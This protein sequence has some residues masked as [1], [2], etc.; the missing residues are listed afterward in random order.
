MLI[1]AE[2]IHA[3]RLRRVLLT[4]G[5]ASGALCIADPAMAA[6]VIAPG[7]TGTVANP[8]PN[9]T[10][11]CTGTTTG[12]N[13]AST[14]TGSGV[15]IEGGAEVNGVAGSEIRID[16]N[17]GHVIVGGGAT[18]GPAIL[19]D[20]SV[21]VIGD[22][23][24]VDIIDGSVVDQSGN[25]AA[26]IF[27]QG[28]NA[29]IGIGA[30]SQVTV[31]RAVQVHGGG[32]GFL[33]ASL[34]LEAG[35]TLS[36]SSGFVASAMIFGGTDVQNFSI[37]GRIEANDI[38]PVVTLI[39]AGDGNDTILLTATTRFGATATSSTV[40]SFVL[41]GGLGFDRMFFD[42]IDQSLVFDTIGIEQLTVDPG[43]G[44]G[45]S[46][47]RGTHE[48]QE[49][50]VRNGQLD[51]FGQAA[52]GASS[53][54]VDIQ[55]NNLVRFFD[56]GSGVLT[57]RLSGS[58]VF[59]YHGGTH[60][61]AS[62]NFLTGQFLVVDGT[63]VISHS[64][65][66]GD[67]T[68]TNYADVI[69]RDVFIDNTLS[70]NG[71]YIIDGVSTTLTGTNSMN[72][73]ITIRNGDLVIPDVAA[74]GNGQATTP[75]TII[76]EPAGRLTLDISTVQ[77]LDNILVGSGTLQKFLAGDLIINR[78]NSG[79]N[80]Q[81]NLLGG[82]TFVNATDA[83]GTGVIFLNA[84][85]LVTGTAFV[86]NT[87]TGTGEIIRNNSGVTQLLANNSQF[88]GQII[89]N[90]GS[91]LVTN[92]NGLGSATVNLANNTSL[93]VAIASGSTTVNNAISG[94]GGFIKTGLGLVNLTGPNTYSGG[95]DISAGTLRVTGS[96]PLGSGGVSVTT[97][98]TL[99]F[100]NATNATFA[101]AMVGGGTFR[102]LG[103][104]QLT[105]T[106]PFSVGALAID[107]GRVRINGNAT[108]HATVAS[109]AT[110]DGTGRIIGNVI[111]NGTVAPGNSIGTLNVQGNYV[112]GAN[113][114]LDIEFDGSGAIDLLNVTGT[115]TLNGG[116]LRFISLGNAEGSGGTFLTAAGGVTGTFANVQ[117]VGAQLP[118]AVIYQ[119]NSAIMAPSVLTARPSTFN[120]QF[121]AAA[122][123]GF[124][125]MDSVASAANLPIEGKNLW[126]QG[127]GATGKRSASGTTLGYDH[128]SYGMSGGVTV[129]VAENVVIGAAVGWA[130]G[131]IDLGSNGGG[132]DQSSV[133]AGLY[134]RYNADGFRLSA[135][136]VY[137]K[138]DQSTLRNVSFN[139]FSASVDGETKSDLYGGY[140]GLAVP[141]GSTGGWQ[142]DGNVRGGFIHQSQDAYVESGASPLRLA[143][144]KQSVDTVEGQ[145]GLSARKTSG[146][147]DLRLGLG[148]RYVSAQ[149]DRTIPVTFAA[150]NAIISLQGDERDNLHSYV[151]LG[152]GYSVSEN[153]KLNLG[154]AGQV[155]TTD[156]HEARVGLTIGF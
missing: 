118:L 33:G 4:I 24:R 156:R 2:T 72:G 19:R 13:V 18:P 94:G 87:L 140:L 120:A 42:N 57:Q 137:G 83:L 138:V 37:D 54:L 154:Y 52:F 39:D 99:V 98:A 110:L 143:V 5:T 41:R 96:G 139:G 123:T 126:L 89:A 153:V 59:E 82:R 60:E 16:G 78:S 69:L 12:I 92:G 66:F 53:S 132:G 70:G 58:G 27:V 113:A 122:D 152:I 147:V 129:A 32:P 64:E 65:A 124:A 108:T 61:F 105:F 149:G 125:F 85:T 150:S 9:S 14:N 115:A 23:A 68:V 11:V 102:K 91:F 109:G 48:F 114:F 31:S 76:V 119:P 50:I 107:A 88:S 130:K 67:A 43:G 49:I 136:A 111:N 21:T 79:F 3:K 1:C 146:K 17:T 104:G 135:G 90:G 128:N 121:L 71:N 8:G 35:A 55:G 95:T 77:T 75:A 97:G 93:E 36:A 80:G 51:V 25:A 141:L 26:L 112:H 15:R 144:A 22:G 28:S 73:R 134:A 148:A 155:G 86:N 34:S 6:C 84:T 29:S 117:T 56:T 30:G 131:D 40:P 100:E 7:G 81:V 74:L 142:I 103:T 133:L 44:G 47:I 127:F 38:N 10:V 46:R 151:D 20:A 145:V 106:N 45:V 116:T 63:A 101:N 62:Q